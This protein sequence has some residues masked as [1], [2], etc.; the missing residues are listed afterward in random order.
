MFFL[1]FCFENALHRYLQDISKGKTI[2]RRNKR[3]RVKV[4]LSPVKFFFFWS[5]RRY[6]TAITSISANAP[7]GSAATWK[8]TRAGYGSLK[9]I[10]YTSLRVPKFARS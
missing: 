4:Y 6:F 3:K 2:F 10:A 7:L 8:A 1:G 5:C 9:Y